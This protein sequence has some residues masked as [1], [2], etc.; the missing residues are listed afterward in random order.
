MRVYITTDLEGVAG[1][2]LDNQV[3]G[4]SPEYDKARRLLTHEVNAAVEGAL[5]GGATEVLVDDGHA[6]GSNFIFEELH[7]QA[8]Y[9]MGGARPDWLPGLG[10]GFDAS[11]FIGCHA[12]AGTMG[13][14]R[15]HTMSSVAWH[16]MWVNGR[17]MGEIG[18]W[19]A[20]AGHY[21]VPCLLVTGCQKA[22]DEAAAL[23]PGIETLTTKRALSRY[24]AVLE[25]APKVQQSIRERARVALSKA[26]EIRPYEVGEPVEIRVE[27]SLTGHADAVR[28]IPGRERLDA[29]TIAY[30]GPDVVGAFRML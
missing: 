8:C 19:V 1:V 23:V 12:M 6:S 18:L 29:R 15:D 4:S 17:L 13:A 5:A 22:C 10:R 25:P 21:G 28:I 11:F 26:K 7:P 2:L 16:N 14:V 20:I 30:R 24:S 27:Y 3:G 9:V